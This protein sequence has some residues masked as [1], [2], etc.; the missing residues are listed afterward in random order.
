MCSHGTH[1]ILPPMLEFVYL[2]E[3]LCTQAYGILAKCDVTI[4]V[5]G[6]AIMVVYNIDV[7]IQKRS[8]VPLPTTTVLF[9]LANGI[10][11]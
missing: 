8:R 11:W 7:A 2:Q 9:E 10:C 6:D 5:R 4:L 1:D 3:K